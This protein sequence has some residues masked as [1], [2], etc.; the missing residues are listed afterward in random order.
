MI[1]ERKTHEAITQ[2]CHCLEHG[3][4]KRLML[5]ESSNV[6]ETDH[7][8]SL[9]R[10][11]CLLQRNEKYIS[12]PVLKASTDKGYKMTNQTLYVRVI[13]NVISY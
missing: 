8:F 11:F 1:L 2:H 10:T 7:K 3:Q 12:K 9:S 5:D 6:F 13:M 4:W